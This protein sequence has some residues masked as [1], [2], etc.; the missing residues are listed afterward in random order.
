MP[1]RLRRPT[2]SESRE[3]RTGLYGWRFQRTDDDGDSRIFDVFK[4]E[5]GWHVHKSYL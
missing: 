1:T 5:D 3:P 2:S 4:G